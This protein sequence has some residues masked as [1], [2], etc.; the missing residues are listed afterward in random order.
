MVDSIGFSDP[1]SSNRSSREREDVDA[2]VDE[3]D[4]VDV[5]DNGDDAEGD[6]DDHGDDGGSG[7]TLVEAAR[8]SDKSDTATLPS[9]RIDAGS[10]A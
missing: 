7:E 2:D 5:D 10:R 9:A 4:D 6:E 8:G 1:H 3:D